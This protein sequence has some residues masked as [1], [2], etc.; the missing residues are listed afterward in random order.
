MHLYEPIH[1][2]SHQHE[3]VHRKAW[4]V[5][6]ALWLQTTVTLLLSA[7]HERLASRILTKGNRTDFLFMALPELLSLKFTKI[8][9]GIFLGEHIVLLLIILYVILLRL[10]YWLITTRS[11]LL[12]FFLTLCFLIHESNSLLF[13]FWRRILIIFRIG[14]FACFGI[15]TSSRR[16]LFWLV[17]ILC[18]LVWGQVLLRRGY[19]AWHWFRNGCESLRVAF[20]ENLFWHLAKFCDLH[21]IGGSL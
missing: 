4:E 14:F 5:V 12:L 1:G 3:L 13:L 17:N 6:Y 16:L 2:T 8:S 11:H 10:I 18:F 21:F 15:Q 9:E 20:P 19:S 7:F